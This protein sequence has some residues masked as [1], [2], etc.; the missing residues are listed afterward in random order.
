MEE[1]KRIITGSI[2]VSSDEQKKRG[3]MVEYYKED[4]IKAGVPEK[5]IFVELARSGSMN[6]DKDIDYKLEDGIFWVGFKIRKNRPKLWDWLQKVSEN[7][8]SL[9]KTTKWDRLIRDI[10]LGISLI[11][12]CKQKGTEVTSTQDTN[13][14]R[15][16]PYLIVLAED[17][18]KA[19]K[20]RIW[21]SKEFKFEK[22]LYIGTERKLGYKKTKIEIGDRKYLHLVPNKEENLMMKDIFFNNNYKEVCSKHNITPNTYYKIRKDRFYCGYIKYKGVEKKGIHEPLISEEE[23]DKI[24]LR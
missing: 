8:I 23:W 2:R 14:E 21:K 7:K 19:T 24:Q 17:E 16:I 20:K 3:Q 4:L 15:V 9:H 18:A 12:F 13:D 10:P 5:N 6:E 11:R 1:D 22:G